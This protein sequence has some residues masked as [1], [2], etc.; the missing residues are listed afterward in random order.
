MKYGKLG[1]PWTIR[2]GFNR[3]SSAINYVFSRQPCLMK[4]EGINP[5][6]T[7]LDQSEP[8]R[9]DK[10][11]DWDL[12]FSRC[13]SIEG[14]HLA[15]AQNDPPPI[16]GWFSYHDQKSVGQKGT[17]ILSQSHL[18][19]RPQKS[20]MKM[21]GGP[22]APRGCQGKQWQWHGSMGTKWPTYGMVIF[23][24][25]PSIWSINNFEPYPFQLSAYE[26]E[27]NIPIVIFVNMG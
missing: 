5:G 16:A 2:C 14:W 22:L 12:W 17:I 7:P 18:T 15:M 26:H 20:S 4:L 8:K 13:M 24:W 25:K 9:C 23:S 11:P 10:N 1:N 19:I 3:N 21:V 6:K 27:Y